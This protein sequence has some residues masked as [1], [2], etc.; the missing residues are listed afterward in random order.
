MERA[1]LITACAKEVGCSRKA[2]YNV[3]AQRKYKP[4]PKTVPV[5][6]GLSEAELRKKHDIKFIIQQALQRLDQGTF[7]TDS[8]FIRTNNLQS[9]PGF[10][11]YLEDSTFSQ[12]KGRAGGTLYWSHPASITK[13]KQEG[14]L[15]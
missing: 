9:H 14:I 7:I 13:M 8:D 11:P 10:R 4:A 1:E 3:L 15:R 6:A 5:T 2:I 12:Y